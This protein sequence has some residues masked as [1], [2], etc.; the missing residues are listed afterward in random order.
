MF[1]LSALAIALVA[2]PAFAANYTKINYKTEFVKLVQG[3]MLT[4]PLVKLQVS[5][6]GSIKGRGAIWDVNGQWTWQNGYFC[7]NL[8][9]GGME[10]GYNC[11]E[12]GLSNGKVRFTSD[13]G[14]GQSAEFKLR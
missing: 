7:R 9:W 2:T 4:R 1:R 8:N 13:E 5:S 10:L 12:V 14:T 6:A 3:K 11:Q